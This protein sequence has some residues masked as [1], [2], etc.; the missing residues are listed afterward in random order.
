MR[1]LYEEK[2]HN[3]ANTDNCDLLVLLEMEV[4][5]EVAGPLHLREMLWGKLSGYTA[6]DLVVIEL[7]ADAQ[8]F[9]FKQGEPVAVEEGNIY[10]YIDPEHDANKVE[11]ELN[12][13][14]AIVRIEKNNLN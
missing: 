3:I 6:D 10:N 5:D 12:A 11:I 8:L 13:C 1:K 7:V 2:Q 4:D 14:A 9:P